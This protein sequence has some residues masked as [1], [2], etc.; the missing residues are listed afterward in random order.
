LC[1]TLITKTSKY[2]LHSH[3]SH[4]TRYWQ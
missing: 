2:I 3:F 1:L 4:F